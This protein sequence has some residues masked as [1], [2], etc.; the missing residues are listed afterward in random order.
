[1][2][3][4]DFGLSKK[5]K[6]TEVEFLQYCGTLLFM[7]PQVLLRE[8]YTYK[9]DVWSMGVLLFYMLNKDT[10]PFYGQRTKELE[11]DVI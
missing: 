5:V 4:A 8:A 7:S 1:M 6:S 9:A 10:T 3:I 2:K 11:A